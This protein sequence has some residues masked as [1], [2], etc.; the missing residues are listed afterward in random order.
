MTGATSTT[1]GGGGAAARTLPLLHPSALR[2][3]A[4]LT[5]P[6]NICF[7]ISFPTIELLNLHFNR[8]TGAPQSG[9][10]SV[11]GG[12]SPE[13]RLVD[14]GASVARLHSSPTQIASQKERDAKSRQIKELPKQ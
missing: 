7:I 4:A 5:K 11:G 13:S 14:S 8:G 1:G 2:R 10:C 9:R 12:C 3:S 6:V